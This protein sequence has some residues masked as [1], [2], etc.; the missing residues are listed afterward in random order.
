M[1]NKQNIPTSDQKET[2]QYSA[3]AP[4]AAGL[5]GAIA[6]FGE[7]WGMYKRKLKTFLSQTLKL[8]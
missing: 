3:P 2:T 5:P 6:L 1:N 8:V 7:S 4:A